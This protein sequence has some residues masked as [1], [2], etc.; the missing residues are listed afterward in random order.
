MSFL[1]KGRPIVIAEYNPA[2]PA[3]FE[4]ERERFFAACG[5]DAFTR[6]E[7]I[8]STAVAGLAAKPVI[9]MMP[10]IRSLD[11]APPIIEALEL[12]GYEYVPQ[13]EH[14]N[15][16]GEGM[17]SRRYLRKDDEFGVR[18][19]QVHM[20]EHG[21]E[22]WREH[23][24]FRN[25]LRVFPAAAAE[26][27]QLKRALADRFNAHL[28]AESE[29]NAGYT[30]YKT[31]FIERIKALARDRVAKSKPIMIVDY[32][33]AWARIFERERASLAAALG[34]LS[35][36]IEHVG[37][38]S[39]PG[40]AAKPKVDIALGVRSMRD[41]SRVLDRLR[42]AGYAMNDDEGMPDDWRVFGKVEGGTKIA[43]LHMVPYGGDRWR[44]YIAFRDALRADPQLAAEYVAL[45]RELAAEFG[46][47]RLGYT[48]AKTDFIR[49]VERSAGVP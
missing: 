26:Y 48:E 12:L 46:A 6:I 45:K 24:L 14:A 31:D 16:A 18:T 11:D 37:S 8:G 41:G 21:S 32:D 28:T 25:Y 36:G 9:D 1:R 27:A 4:A 3:K 35:L 10:G 22:F 17:P 7:H 43:Q 49:R 5:R 30:D 39:V 47:D 38:T 29:I 2:W 20:V 33:P 34:D 15:E 19:H 44:R 40:L 13:F 23:Q 42:A